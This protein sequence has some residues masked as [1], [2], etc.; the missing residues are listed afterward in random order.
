VLGELGAIAQRKGD[1]AKAAEHLDRALELF[2]RVPDDL[3]GISFASAARGVINHLEGDLAGAR[4]YYEA[5]LESGSKSGDTDSIAS[6]LV[7]LGEVE[8]A[9]AAFDR[10]YEHY[11]KSLELFA[12]RGK[13]VAIAYCA[14]IIAGISVKHRNKPSDA[15]IFFGFANALR[16]EI[17]S[18]I[19]SFNAERLEADKAAA[20]AAMPEDT[21]EVSWNAGASLDVDEFLTLVKDLE[22][23]N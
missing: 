14:E 12:S 19:E 21:F 7:N 2:E 13:K 8:E 10:A 1:M 15:A 17:E 3:H 22:L 23:S 18:P 9:E 4:R 16:E 11:T 20:K 6:A 5:A